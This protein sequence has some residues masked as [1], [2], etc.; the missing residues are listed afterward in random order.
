MSKT[1]VTHIVAC[2]KITPRENLILTRHQIF[3]SS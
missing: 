2:V 1:R 3:V